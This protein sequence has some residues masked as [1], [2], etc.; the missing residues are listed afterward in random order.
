MP[1][2]ASESAVAP[3]TSLQWG[4]SSALIWL[5]SRLCRTH[6][7]VSV[8]IQYADWQ[9]DTARALAASCQQ[10]GNTVIAVRSDASGED[11]HEHSNAGRFLTLL[12]VTPAGRAEAIA[13]VFESQSVDDSPRVLLQP[14]VRNLRRVG[15][16]STHRISDGAPWYCIEFAR[17]DSVAVTAGRATGRQLAWHRETLATACAGPTRAAT[18]R[19]ANDDDDAPLIL[20]LL[21]DI[22]SLVPAKPFEIEFALTSDSALPHLLQVRPLA[23]QK[24][25]P[26]IAAPLTLGGAPSFSRDRLS[27]VVG[28]RPVYSLMCDWNPAELIGSHPRPLALGLFQA[29]IA[30]GTWWSARQAL[31]YRRCPSHTVALLKPVA[32]RPYVDLRRS[33]NS[34][35]PD[36]LSDPLSTRLVDHWL[37]QVN[38]RPELHDKV[39][40]EVFTSCR[41]LRPKSIVVNA[42]RSLLGDSGSREFEASLRRLTL[43]LMGADLAAFAPSLLKLS[44]APSSVFLPH[45]DIANL[46]RRARTAAFEFAQLARIAFIAEA[47][48]RSAVTLEALSSERAL[49][50]RLY[51]GGVSGV[52]H[53]DRQA[54]RARARALLR[55]SSFDITQ[56]VWQPMRGD[57]DTQLAVPTQDFSL[58][59]SELNALN[60]LLRGCAPNLSAQQWAA[61]VSAATYAREWGKFMLSQPLAA[62]IECLAEASAERDLNREAL[63]WLTLTECIAAASGDAG[64]EIASERAALAQQRAQAESQQMLSPVLRST[65]DLLRFDSLGTQPNFVGIAP[66]HG[67]L[68]V[69]DHGH[70]EQHVERGDVVAVRHADPGFD[71]LFE[72]GIAGLLTAWGGAHSHMGIR[73]AE[74]GV[75][76]ALGCGE[77]VWAQAQ[78][79]ASVRI[80]PMQAALWLY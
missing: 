15:V 10:L 80:D 35:L 27:H 13:R 37:A 16:A 76:A 33:A 5:S 75:P 49:E 56:P 26:T 52:M 40:F 12:D 18:A 2:P 8:V 38:A 70:P 50:L 69:L 39:E 30:R 53:R 66:R 47:Q 51:A 63:S 36:D 59:P 19:I 6:V 54:T 65:A 17:G 41:D 43:P 20:A 67:P 72:R 9:S 58:R 25:W 3:A 23:T 29:L 4:K 71:W 77:A 55:P 28:T 11:Q 62:L 74:H 64:A 21:R 34:L 60:Q 48:L 73:C 57:I 42:H 1:K 68:R 31:G 78:R 45:R 22:E 79:A 44:D 14:M 46:L 24:H 61:W 32:G 7:P